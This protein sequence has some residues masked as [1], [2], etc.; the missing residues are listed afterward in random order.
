MIIQCS[1]CKSDRIPC[2]CRERQALKQIVE[3]GPMKMSPWT[4]D[5][6]FYVEQT[7]PPC[8]ACGH[9]ALYSVCYGPEDLESTIE[10]AT[11]P[12]KKGGRISRTVM[13]CIRG[14]KEGR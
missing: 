9:G 10:Y 11:G 1:V 6:P 8:R 5:E 13:G 2:D 4:D 7:T 14:H 3:K 12:I